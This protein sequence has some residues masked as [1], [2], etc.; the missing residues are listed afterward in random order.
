MFFPLQS[1]SSSERKLGSLVY[2]SILWN[3]DETKCSTSID[4][5]MR[6]SS[7]C[8]SQVT[9]GNAEHVKGSEVLRKCLILSFPQTHLT[10]KPRFLFTF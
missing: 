3:T 1:A 10:T 8:D 6:R 4:G 7:K 2:Q 9:L 5:L